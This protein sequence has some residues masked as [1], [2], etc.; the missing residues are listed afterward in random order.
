[1]PRAE[2]IYRQVLAVEPGNADATHLLG[3]IA[4]ASGR[5][6]EA[7]DL[8]QRAIGRAPRVPHYHANL[9]NALRDSGRT[10]DA[11]AAYEHAI[12]LGDPSAEVRNNLGIVLQPRFGADQA[13]PARRSGTGCAGRGGGIAGPCRRPR[14]A[15]VGAGGC[16]LL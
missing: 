9:A 4:Q 7:V 6:A 14:G 8:M 5:L 13:G 12:S 16:R 3:M 2:A 10:A 1:L 11:I 15:G